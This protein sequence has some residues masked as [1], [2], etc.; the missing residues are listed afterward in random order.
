MERPEQ[1][2]TTAFLAKILHAFRRKNYFKKDLPHTPQIN[3]ARARKLS[4]AAR[5][6]APLSSIK[7][8]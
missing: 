2:Q 8:F 3:Q 5:A 6:Q 4:V 1:T 7:T